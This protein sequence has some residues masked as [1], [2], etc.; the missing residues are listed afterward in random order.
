VE[1]RAYA[2]AS[3]AAAA[4][5]R[6]PPMRSGDRGERER[7]HIDPQYCDPNSDAA[8]TVQQQETLIERRL[9]YM[10]LAT[11]LPLPIVTDCNI[12]AGFRVIGPT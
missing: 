9:E 10:R 6:I 1:S 8:L 3:S 12:R 5:E 2:A 11:D 7:A 4:L